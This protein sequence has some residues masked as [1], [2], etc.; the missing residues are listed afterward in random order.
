MTPIEELRKVYED[1]SS[2]HY[3]D[4]MSA[5]VPEIENAGLLAVARYSAQRQQQSDNSRGHFEA[6]PLWMD[7]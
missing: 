5:T 2:A 7:E 1:A 3:A 4:D 6:N